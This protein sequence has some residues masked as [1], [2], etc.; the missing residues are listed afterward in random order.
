MTH[1]DRVPVGR[2]VRE[3]RIAL[4]LV[5]SLLVANAVGLGLGVLPLTQAV[6]AAE[7]RLAL[8]EAALARAEA[9]VA[10]AE[11][12]RAGRDR[13]VADLATFY[14]Q[15][16]PGSL[17][18]ARHVLHTRLAQLAAAEGVSYLRQSSNTDR[19]R[20]S[21][22]ERLRVQMTLSGRYDDIR[23]F[24]HAIEAQE[25]FVIIENVVLG[26][27]AQPG[28]PLTLTLELSTYYRVPESH[29]G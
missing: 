13:A 24:V 16:L 1:G 8:A 2:V 23:R 21:R 10:A 29:G 5:G 25:P 22:L 7:H 18:E 12:M 20:D 4:T 9:D 15:V 28:A 11:A 19:A 26:E 27:G 3:H 17:A 6:A 14:E